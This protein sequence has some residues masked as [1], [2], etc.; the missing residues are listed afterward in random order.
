MFGE[1]I[2]KGRKKEKERKK[3]NKKKEGSGEGREGGT[4]EEI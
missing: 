3:R 2:V 1:R 4:K